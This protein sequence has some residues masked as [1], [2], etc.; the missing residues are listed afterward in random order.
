MRSDADYLAI[1][2]EKYSYID[3]ES[4][5]GRYVIDFGHKVTNSIVARDEKGAWVHAWVWVSDDE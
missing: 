3:G 1:A 2:R 5:D 4:D